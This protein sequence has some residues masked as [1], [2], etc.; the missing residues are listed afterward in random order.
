MALELPERLKVFRS[1]RRRPP[2][3][4]RSAGRPL[5]SAHAALGASDIALGSVEVCGAAHCVGGAAH[6]VCG[7]CVRLSHLYVSRTGFVP[8]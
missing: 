8:P 1:P 7:V 6:E 3:H 2:E 5:G 4:V